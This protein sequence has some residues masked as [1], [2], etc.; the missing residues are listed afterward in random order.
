[1]VSKI[2]VLS[3]VV[4]L[5][6]K[7][8]N[9]DLSV[10][11]VWMIRLLLA[12]SPGII[13]PDEYFQ[14][15]EPLWQLFTKSN[16]HLPWEFQQGARS[17]GPLLVLYG[18]PVYICNYFELHQV[19]LFLMIKIEMVLLSLIF[20]YFVL[21]YAKNDYLTYLCSGIVLC[22][23]NRP[24]SNTIEM[25]LVCLTI[26]F[27]NKPIVIGIVT[28]FGVFTRITYPGFVAPFLILQLYRKMI[29]LPK[30][31]TIVF[32]SKCLIGFVTLTI[33]FVVIDTLVY[34][35]GL[36]YPLRLPVLDNLI[37]N[38]KTENLAQHGLHPRY[39]H[40]LI[41]MPFIYGPF[42]IEWL[43]NFKNYKN[44]YSL[45]MVIPIA[46]MSIFPHQEPRFVIGAFPWLFLALR[47][48]H[49]HINISNKLILAHGLILAFIYYFHQS[50]LLMYSFS[51]LNTHKSGT[52]TYFYKVYDMPSVFMPGQLINNDLDRL[53]VGSMKEK[54][55]KLKSQDRV[56]AIASTECNCYTTYTWNFR[57][58]NLTYIGKFPQ[59]SIDYALDGTV[60][61]YKVE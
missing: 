10:R 50:S 28:A 57:N 36:F 26:L 39:T 3:G 31:T 4:S 17:Y 18:L 23:C 53:P 13:H 52:T 58:K 27:Q 24:F 7:H 5:F 60:C 9:M 22:F 21:K 47:K 37:Y 16:Q 20:D 29:K 35:N 1:M 14:S 19:W 15:I 12:L 38:T 32:Y 44:W 61:V 54:S 46:L 30:L 59:L 25:L 55:I 2:R 11:L 56:L 51:D 40:F 34:N 43:I 33:L 41:N 49:G 48:K 45:F 6:L 42:F 8:Q